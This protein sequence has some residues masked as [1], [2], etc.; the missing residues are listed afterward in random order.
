MQNLHHQIQARERGIGPRTNINP[1]A[2]PPAI[3]PPIL[4]QSSGVL[5]IGNYNIT[6]VI[7]YFDPKTCRIKRTFHCY[8]DEYDIKLHPEESMLFGNLMLQ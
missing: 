3:K 6:K 1:R 5:L 7:I 8:I 4:T 2:C